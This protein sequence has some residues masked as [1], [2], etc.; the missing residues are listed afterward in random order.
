[1]DDLGKKLKKLWK[2]KPSKNAFKGK[3]NVLGTAEKVRTPKY[4]M[5]RCAFSQKGPEAEAFSCMSRPRTVPHL[6]RKLCRGSLEQILCL[7]KG[8]LP[9]GAV[10]QHLL[11]Q[12]K[13]LP[14]DPGL[15]SPRR[16][17]LF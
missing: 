13:L 2:P 16:Q 17:V 10:S 15:C 9:L 3:A 4:C 11:G 5:K 8:I 14:H 7:N 12:S 6:L 1:M